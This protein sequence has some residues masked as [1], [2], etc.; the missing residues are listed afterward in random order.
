MP[1]KKKMSVA[2]ILA[3]ARKAD[4]KD[5]GGASESKPAE[6]AS[7]PAESATVAESSGCG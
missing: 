5:G 2:D 1:E 7:S 6:E 4:N 3:A